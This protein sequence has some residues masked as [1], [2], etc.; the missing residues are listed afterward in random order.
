MMVGRSLG[1]TFPRKTTALGDTTFE[2][3]GFTGNGV[4]DISFSLREGEI[5]GIGGLVGAGRTELAQLIFGIASREKGELYLRGKK[6]EI[7]SP[8]DAVKNR[9]ALIPEDRKQQGLLLE[10]SVLENIGLPLLNKKQTASFIHYRAIKDASTQQK[11]RLNIKTP[12]LSQAVRNLSGG[13][14]QKVVLAKWLAAEC[15]YL[16]FDEPTRGIDVGAKQEIY[17]LMMAL[18]EQGKSIIMISSEM[19]ELIGISDRIIVLCEGRLMGTLNK[20]E[21]SQAAI[22]SLASGLITGVKQ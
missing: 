12:A 21:F 1:D 22:L 5:L 2:I 9:I 4:R 13:N 18:A 17:K 20:A 14:Q 15:D 11:D 6:I 8:R 16:I 7:K 3:R 19:E 10:S